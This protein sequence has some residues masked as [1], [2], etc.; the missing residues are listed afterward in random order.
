MSKINL[1]KIFY[2]LAKWNSRNPEKATAAVNK[3]NSN[4]KLMRIAL[5]AFTWQA[6]REAVRRMWGDDILEFCANIVKNDIDSDVKRA[7]IDKLS[8]AKFQN[9]FVE[10][11]M[12][13]PMSH[14][15]KIAIDKITDIEKLAQLIENCGTYLLG[16]PT[17]TRDE[18]A[19]ILVYIHKIHKE[20]A[21]R[22]MIRLYEGTPLTGRLLEN[23]DILD[24][25]ELPVAPQSH[26]RRKGGSSNNS[27][28]ESAK[29]RR[30]EPGQRYFLL[31]YD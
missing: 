4:A 26:S 21:I 7:A 31:P 3:I 30:T 10:T 29:T 19:D 13:N 28:T 14:I 5:N 27:N 9:F 8:G 6:R 25:E 2:R 18:Y 15:R 24:D 16:G 20:K 17:L 11:A 22:Q 12:T 1:Y 23:S